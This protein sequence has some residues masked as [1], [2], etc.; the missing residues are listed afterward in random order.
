MAERPSRK[1]TGLPGPGGGG[2]GQPGREELDDVIRRYSIGWD[3]SRI[4]RLTRAILQLALFEC[5][6]VEDVPVGVAVN[7]AVTFGKEVRRR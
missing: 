1:Q 4:S 3:L 5:Q 2:D 6:W 7:E